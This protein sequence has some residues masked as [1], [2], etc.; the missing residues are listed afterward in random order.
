MPQTVAAEAAAMRRSG[1]L[2]RQSAFC[3]TI[4]LLTAA[5]IRAQE[6]PRDIVLKALEVSNRESQ[7]EKQYAYVERTQES[8]L[9]NGGAVKTKESHT[10]DVVQLQGSQFR[11][12]I[13][14]NDKPLTAKEE[15]DEKA[16]QEK[17]AANRKKMAAQRAAETPEQRQKRLDAREKAKQKDREENAD[18]VASFDLRI[19]ADESIDGKPVWVIE[20]SPHSGYKFKFKDNSFMSKMKGRIWIA[21]ED[22]QPVK[23][24]AET[25]E[26]IAFGAI[27]ARVQKGAHLSIEYARVNDEVWL[28]K[29]FRVTAS[30][31]LLLVKGFH[32]EL[33]QS[34]RD[35]KRFSVESR[36]VD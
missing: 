22:Y 10:W 18:I 3:T 16:R 34:F 24:E 12:L 14:H 19:L 29:F 20:G 26:T 25:L 35:Y 33:E 17:V 2:R 1:A 27:L 7:A 4:L 23:I 5:Q 36:I 9:D 21:K 8:K 31:R 11:R 28:P 32:E 13:Q 15:A 6:S 30:A